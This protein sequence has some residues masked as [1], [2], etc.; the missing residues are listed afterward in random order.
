MISSPAM[1]EGQS[2]QRVVSID[3]LR[4][5]VMVLMIF[6]NDLGSLHH[7]P[8]WLKHVPPNADGMGLADTVFPAFLFMVGLSLPFA[9]D[10]R[11][12]KGD[13]EWQLVRHVL[14]RSLALLVMGVFVVNGETLDA[15]AMGMSPYVYNPICCF[16]FLLIWSVYPT[17][18]TRLSRA[19]VL[20]LKGLGVAVLVTLAWFYRGSEAGRVVRFTRQWWGILGL[21]GWS[22]L[23]SGLIVI[24]AKNRFVAIAAAW[25]GFCIL[26]MAA[27]AGLVPAVVMDHVPDAISGGTLTGLTMGGVLTSLIFRYFRTRGDNTG[28][29]LVYVLFAAGLVGAS[30]VTR[31]YWKL[32]KIEATPAWLFLCSALTML[33]FLLVYWIADVCGKARWFR[34]IEPAGTDTLLCYCMPYFVGSALWLA[35]VPWPDAVLEGGAGLVKS[36]CYAVLCVF[37]AGRLNK[38]GIHLKL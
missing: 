7:I 8:G 19:R 20:L 26:S 35:H 21:I 23:A 10:Q 30:V 3:I 1:T 37:L 4:A 28:L 5:L 31:P 18:P 24:F 27:K 11:R 6:V 16:A 29:T 2:T 12:R 38:L 15:A 22:Y 36:L 33:G 17:R 25:A 9:I 13:T 34:L 14:V 32:A